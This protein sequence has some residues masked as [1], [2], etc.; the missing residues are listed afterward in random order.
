MNVYRNTSKRTQLY[1]VKKQINFSHLHWDKIFLR[2]NRLIKQVY[3]ETKKHSM[4]CAHQLQMYIINSIELKIFVFKY[5]VLE[6]YRLYYLDKNIK[7]R[8]DQRYKKQKVKI[9]S[10]NQQINLRKILKQHLIYICTKP[11]F[12]ARLPRSYKQTCILKKNKFCITKDNYYYYQN[13][14][15][16]EKKL[17]LPTHIKEN[18][19]YC[20]ET[21]SYVDILKF[22]K[23][24][25][26]FNINNI[27]YLDYVDCLKYK[28]FLNN[29]LDILNLTDCMWYKF[30]CIKKVKHQIKMLDDNSLN[31]SKSIKS[32]KYSLKFRF[33]LSDIRFSRYLELKK[34]NK[35]A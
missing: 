12:D 34:K 13:I 27:E 32:F 22:Y 19:L 2:V 30:N 28:S 33:L 18:I 21:L 9:K 6:L 4:R 17:E 15:Y 20:I 7:Y 35:I 5:V 10:Q 25:Y 26:K 11:M 8:F 24:K 29:I 16:I 31:I 1:E 14:K 23:S 3:Y